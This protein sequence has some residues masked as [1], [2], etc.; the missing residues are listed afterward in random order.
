MMD[1]LR[2]V[3]RVHKR[4]FRI[5][6]NQHLIISDVAP[7]GWPAIEALMKEY[8]LDEFET[9]SG[10]RLNSMA[11]VALPTCGLAMAESERYLSDLITKIEAI[12]N[13]YGLKDEP[14]TTC[15]TGCPNGC[16][17]PYIAEIGLTGRA[18]GKYN[19]Y[20]GG[21]FHGQRLNKMYLENVGE[22]AILEALD[23]RLAAMSATA[24]PASASA[25]L[26]FAQVM[27][28]RRKRNVFSTIERGL[29]RRDRQ[30]ILRS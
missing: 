25:I 30:P 8:G 22:S 21:D 12:L 23:K 1:G 18:S 2:A 13:T 5:A 24:S 26:P 14:I 4:T 10:L 17:R 29:T 15:M 20:L 16:A 19:L 9:R 7:E 11:C 27:S 28:S 6:P 3:A